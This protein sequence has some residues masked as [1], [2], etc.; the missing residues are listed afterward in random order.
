[1]HR[2]ITVVVGRSRKWAIRGGDLQLRC[3]AAVAESRR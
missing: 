1:M 3:S 2:L